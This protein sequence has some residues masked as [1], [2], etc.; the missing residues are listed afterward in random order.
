MFK[1]GLERINGRDIAWMVRYEGQGNRHKGLDGGRIRTLAAWDDDLGEY[2]E[3][4]YFG[5]G[6]W[7]EEARK[8]KDI[9]A[10][11]RKLILEFN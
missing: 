11:V 6:K 2:Y 1:E 5:D 9:E 8:D 10:V 4:A 3:E 7:W